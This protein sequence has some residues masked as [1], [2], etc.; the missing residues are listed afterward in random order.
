MKIAPVD[1]AG[2]ARLI[3]S[4]ECRSIGILTGA[5]VSVASGIPDFRSP[6]GMYDSLQPDLITASPAERALMFQDPTYVVSWDIFHNNQ[7]PYLEVRRPFILG[8]REETW[9][10]TIAHRFAELLHTK[11]QKLT[12]VYTQNID[13]LDRQCKK[14]PQEKIVSVHGSIAE[15]TCENCGHQADF[16]QFCDAIRSNIKDIY[17]QDAQAPETSTPILCTKCQLPFVKPRTVLF[18]RSLPSEF[19]ECV[20]EDLPSMDLLIVAGTS[21]VVSPANSIVYSVPDTTVRAVINREPVGADLGIDYSVNAKRDFF[22]RGNCD[23]VFLELME[24]LGWTDELV[25]ILDIL[26]PSSASLVRQTTG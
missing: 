1:L 20:Q 26:P 4:P 7:F 9:K 21:L 6:G 8:T 17:K 23:E 24:H 22:A 10:A 13:G 15:A 11:T 25:A 18:G 14:I 19:F 5:G 3:I 2:L 16:D 12:R